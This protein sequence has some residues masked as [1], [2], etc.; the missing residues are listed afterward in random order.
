MELHICGS[1]FHNERYRVK[2]LSALITRSQK[3]EDICLAIRL[4]NYNKHLALKSMYSK[5]NL[6]AEWSSIEVSN[7]TLRTQASRRQISNSQI[8]DYAAVNSHMDRDSKGS[9]S[10]LP[11]EPP[12][13]PCVRFTARCYRRYSA[14][15]PARHHLLCL[16]EPPKQ[17]VSAVPGC[18]PRLLGM[19]TDTP[20]SGLSENVSLNRLLGKRWAGPGRV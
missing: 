4:T 19:L 1:D 6:R 3:T 2:R 7:R 12:Q 18:A 5:A 13:W 16:L 11:T 10:D 14:L 8:P 20:D 17:Q 15:R 9:C